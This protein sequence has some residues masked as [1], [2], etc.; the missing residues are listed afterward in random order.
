MN[1]LLRTASTTLRGMWRFRWLGVATAWGVGVVALVVLS[2]VPE[3]FEA[4]ARIFVNTDSILKPLMR[5]LTVQPNDEQRIAMLGRVMISRPNVETLVQRGGLDAEAKSPAERDRIIDGVMKTIDLRSAGRGNLYTLAYKDTSPE[6]ARNVV[7][8]LATM[9]IE[10]NKGS[11]ASDTDAAKRFIEEQIA[12]YEKKLQEAENRLK[13]FRLH[14]LGMTP[15]D[16]RDF[17]VRM[18]EASNQLNQARLELREAERGRDAL[19]A[20]L[21]SEGTPAA[22]ASASAS[23]AAVAEIDAR[24]EAQRRN[25]DALL[26]RYTPSH[27]DVV[28]ARRV[29]TELEEQRHQAIVAR[30]SDA[31]A[32]PGASAGG[33]RAAE[34]LKVSLTQAEALVASLST[35]VAEF[36]SRYEKLKASAALVPQLEAEYAQLNRDYDVNKRNFESLVARRESATISGDMQSVEGVA[37]FRLVDPPRVSPR[38][39][40]PNRLLLF[41]AALILALAAGLAAAYIARELRPTFADGRALREL[42]GLRLIGTVSENLS[43]GER[44]TNRR[45]VYRFLAAVG[46]LAG[47]YVAGFIAIRLA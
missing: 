20:G 28:G 16:G 46:A 33:P 29:I 36:A 24:I 2:Q 13:Q 45:G 5:D 34:Q 3:R 31:G 12:V 35:R 10:S 47:L 4:T 1:D 27:P 17:F 11:K 39:V 41:P 6:R 7:E 30:R 23:A 43:E 22:A 9:F 40:F 21:A 18:S 25:L 19:R 42:T 37:D 8:L 32:A 44:E 38:P 26:L 14:Y 15:G